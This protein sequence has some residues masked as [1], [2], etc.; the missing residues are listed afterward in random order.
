LDALL[1]TPGLTVPVLIVFALIVLIVTTA[2]SERAKAKRR[3][4]LIALCGKLNIQYVEED[5]YQ[6]VT[7]YAGFDW[8]SV[9]DSKIAS[10]TMI[11]A[12]YGVNLKMFDYRYETGSGRSRPVHQMSIVAVD[13]DLIFNQIKIRPETFL[14]RATEAIGVKNIDF[15]SAEFGR[16]Y[17]I[18]SRNKKFAYDVISPRMMEFLLANRGWSIELM[19]RTIMITN[20]RILSADEYMQAFTFIKQFRELLPN[21]LVEA[22]RGTSPSRGH[23]C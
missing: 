5:Q 4:S 10:N 17:C 7:E 8:L 11:G 15:E 2:L 1:Q 12:V 13:T 3:Q 16:A 19:G 22:L 20:E 9:G 18:R 21:Y 6:I 23:S 14:D